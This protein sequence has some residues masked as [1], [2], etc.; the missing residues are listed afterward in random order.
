[1]I[2]FRLAEKFRKNTLFLLL[3]RNTIRLPSRFIV[4]APPIYL[5][6]FIREDQ[7]LLANPKSE[8]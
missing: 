2:A 5:V 8:N 3:H 1:M 7:K 6:L 4:I